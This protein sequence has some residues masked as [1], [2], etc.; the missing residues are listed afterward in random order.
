MYSVFCNFYAH[1]CKKTTS[2]NEAAN[3]VI[4]CKDYIVPVHVVLICRWRCVIKFSVRFLSI[5]DRFII[6]TSYIQQLCSYRIQ[7]L[8]I[9]SSGPHGQRSQCSCWTVCISGM[10]P[11]D[12]SARDVRMYNLHAIYYFAPVST[13]NHAFAARSCL[14]IERCLCRHCTI[15]MYMM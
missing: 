14:A 15:Y 13:K 8:N 2:L 9:S 3:F 1:P 11:C 7:A 6:A 4:A 12:A 5:V 10:R